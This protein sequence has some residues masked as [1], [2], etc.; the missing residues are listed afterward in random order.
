MH[1]FLYPVPFW[2]YLLGDS[3][4]SLRITVVQ[5]YSDFHAYEAAGFL[6][7]TNPFE[8]AMLAAIMRL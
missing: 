8:T 3:M 5:I 4:W 6:C 7:F 1:T 2:F